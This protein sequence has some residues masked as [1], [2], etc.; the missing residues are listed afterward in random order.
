VDILQAYA[1]TV[2]PNHANAQYLEDSDNDDED[3]KD[4]Q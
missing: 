1:D 4:Q 3:D 2:G